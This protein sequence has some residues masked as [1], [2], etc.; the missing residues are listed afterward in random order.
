MTLPERLR[1]HAQNEEMVEN[2][3]TEA[4][5]LLNEAA[6]EV[7]RLTDLV[8]RQVEGV[9]GFCDECCGCGEIGD[10]GHSSPDECVDCWSRDADAAL[11]GENA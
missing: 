3:F 11:R 1:S 7:E 6:D 2:G 8:R 4:G 9:S 10:S 5:R